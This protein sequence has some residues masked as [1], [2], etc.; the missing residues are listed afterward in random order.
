M[1]LARRRRTVPEHLNMVTLL[2]DRHLAEG[3]GARTAFVTPDGALT[4]QDLYRLMNRMGHGLK[5]LG[6]EPEQRVMLLLPD[7]PAFVASFLGAMRLGAVPVPVNTLA[8]PSDYEYVLNDSRAKVLVAGAETVA[9]IDPIRAR[10]PFLQ[11]VVVD[12]TEHP[13]AI[14]FDRLVDAQQDEL[15]PAPTHRD[16]PSYWLYSSG[17][18]GHPKGVVHC[19]RDMVSC[20]S[21]YARE[22]L[23]LGADDL[24]FSVSRLFFSYGLGNSLYL[25]LWA[26]ASSLLVPDRPDPARVLAVLRRHRP[27]IFFSVPTSY[28]ALL[29]VIDSG[30]EHDFRSLRLA[31]SAGEPLPA[32]ILERWR[33]ATGIELLDGLGSTEVGYIFISNRVGR[34][35]PGSSGQPLSGYELRIVDETR[36]DVAPGEVGTLLVKAD[37]AA[38][39]YWHQREK[40]RRT[41]LGRWLRTGDKYVRDADGYYTYVGREDDLFKV[42]GQWVFP[43]EVEQRLLSHA[44]VAECAVVGQADEHGLIKPHAYVVLKGEPGSEQRARELREFVGKQLP[45]FKT[46]QRI[47]FVGELPKTATGKIQRFRLRDATR[48]SR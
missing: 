35:R 32:P 39:H 11:H 34:V 30:M 15:A 14:A 17:A 22:V 28:A 8:G 5:T 23:D 16:D 31:I 18:T 27:T 33:K 13:G 9:K 36:R 7:G 12:G 10:C 1:S 25:P 19:H 42:S 4:Y 45:L 40:T 20:I 3:R 2:V 37:S 47:S 44:A 48:P 29:N 6:V 43:L 41:F 38:A 26:G 24:L 46:P 21:T